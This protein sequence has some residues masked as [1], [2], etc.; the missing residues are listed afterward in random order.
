MNCPLNLLFYPLII[1][2]N[3]L[4]VR[5]CYKSMV[6]II[7]KIIIIIKMIAQK[8][9]KKN[10]FSTGRSRKSKFEWQCKLSMAFALEGK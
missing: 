9:E 10:H 1:V 8:K 4:S 6:D 5:I 2:N 3:N 7:F